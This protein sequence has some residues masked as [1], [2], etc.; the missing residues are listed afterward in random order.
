MGSWRNKVVFPQHLSCLVTTWLHDVPPAIS[1]GT[2]V[3]AG[4]VLNTCHDLIG[5]FEINMRRMNIVLY[6]NYTGHG[7][8]A[9]P[10]LHGS[11]WR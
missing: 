1:R 11:L 9:Q 8:A 10:R 5:V 7:S 4:S 3:L 2:H 6:G